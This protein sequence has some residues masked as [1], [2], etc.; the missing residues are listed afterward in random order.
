MG[1]PCEWHQTNQ[2]LQMLQLWQCNMMNTP[3]SPLLN[4]NQDTVPL[5]RT[6]HKVRLPTSLSRLNSLKMNN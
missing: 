3:L 6:D 1:T 4:K 5:L 2:I